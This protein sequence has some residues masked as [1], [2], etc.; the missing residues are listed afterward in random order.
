M[1]PARTRAWY[2]TL[3]RGLYFLSFPF[4]GKESKVAKRGKSDQGGKFPISGYVT[5]YGAKHFSNTLFLSYWEIPPWTPRAP[6][7]A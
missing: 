4:Q 7:E 2:Q 5:Q 6:M 3:V 1:G